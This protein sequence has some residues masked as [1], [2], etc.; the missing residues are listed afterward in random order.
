MSARRTLLPVVVALLAVTA[1][2]G[3]VLPGGDSGVDGPAVTET[4]PGTADLVVHVDVDGLRDDQSLA[5]LRDLNL[6]DARETAGNRSDI[7]DNDE[8][9]DAL[10]NASEVDVEKLHSVT[11]FARYPPADPSGTL[12]AAGE[13]EG[14][15]E[16]PEAYGAAILVADWETADLVSSIE[17][18][19]RV[20]TDEDATVEPAE[21][22]DLQEEQYRD[23]TLYVPANESRDGAL[24]VLEDGVFAVGPRTAVEDA[25]A[26]QTGDRE[27]MNGTLRQAYDDTPEDGLVRFAV[28]VP[29]DRVPDSAFDTE[30]QFNT[31]LFANVTAVDGAFF[32]GEDTVG[33]QVGLVFTDAQVAGDAADVVDGARQ[34]YRGLVTNETAK[35]LLASENLSVAQDGTSVTVTSEHSV[36]FVKGLLQ[37][38]ANYEPEDEDEPY[39]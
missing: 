3:A 30:S 12:S 35:T 20:E 29:R 1:G 25:V 2:C 24:A 39:V 31:A 8:T 14:E 17:A 28:D 9:F 38:L 19:S 16:G 10:L 36:D 6:S 22:L 5:E 23:H 33:A 27:S 15:T 7:D 11:V 21:P 32:T 34:V 13:G 18:A 37:M 4:V 26:V